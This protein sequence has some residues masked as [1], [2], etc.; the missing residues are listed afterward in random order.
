MVYRLPYLYSIWTPKTVHLIWLIRAFIYTHYMLNLTQLGPARDNYNDYSILIYNN[1]YIRP[2]FLCTWG[3]CQWMRADEPSVQCGWLAAMQ[4][5]VN[6][7]WFKGWLLLK[8]IVIVWSTYLPLEHDGC[9][10]E[11]RCR[12]G[13]ADKTLRADIAGV[14]GTSKLHNIPTD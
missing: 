3:Q 5:L 8:H 2:T 9:V 12:P 14:Y 13:Q 6:Q 1:D 7:Y 10:T 4:L 11:G